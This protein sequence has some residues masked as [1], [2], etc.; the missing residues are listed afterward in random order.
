MLTFL[1]WN[2]NRKSL[3][4]RVARLA[5][6]HAADVVVLAEC[7][8][9]PGDFERAAGGPFGY[10][11]PPGKRLRV[12][13]AVPGA[14]WDLGVDA[15]RWQIF[16]VRRPASDEVLIAATHLPSKLHATPADQH[17]MTRL[18]AADIE[19]EE[20]NR[21]HAR[22]ILVGDL[23]MN[24]F[25]EGVAGAGHLHAVMTRG[26]AGEATRAV[27]GRTF[28]MFYNPMWGSF[29]DRTPGPPG[30][31]YAGPTGAVSY[32]WEMPDQV[33]LRPGVMDRL[34]D[35]AILDTDG[36]DTLLSRDGFPDRERGSDHLPLF[37]RVDV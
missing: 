36:T 16:R 30:T 13:S 11:S 7:E 12:W 33:L 10:V 23:N 27:G 35:L 14:V 4:D 19:Q 32:F 26:K 18:F 34:T 3:A 1:F 8:F 9:G 22:T 31:Y 2:I 6:A 15:P 5:R 28:N 24:P 20:R 37:F 25:E 21:Q 17:L 29:G